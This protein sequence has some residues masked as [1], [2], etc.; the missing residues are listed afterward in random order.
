MRLVG[1]IA[2]LV[3]CSSSEPAKPR[4]APKRV[5]HPTAPGGESNIAR[6]DYIG[7][8]ACRECHEAQYAMWSTSLHRVMNAKVSDAGA[9]IGDFTGKSVAYRDGTAKFE[10]TLDG[11]AMTLRSL[12]SEVRYRI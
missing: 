8:E 10:R 4:D 5:P 12:E 9:V 1:V 7:P 3:A 6:A 11:Y 2:L